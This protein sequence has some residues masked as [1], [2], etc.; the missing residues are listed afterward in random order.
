MQAVSRRL[1]KGLHPPLH[2]WLSAIATVLALAAL[3]L[4][5]VPAADHLGR[6]PSLGLAIVIGCAQLTWYR[7]GVLTSALILWP[8]TLTLLGALATYLIPEAWLPMAHLYTIVERLNAGSD[9]LDWRPALLELL[10]MLTLSLGLL[11]RTRSSLGVPL[12]QA[13]SALLL[14]LD[15]MTLSRWIPSSP[16]L[17]SHDIPLSLVLAL[18]VIAQFIGVVK[19]WQHTATSITRG[20]WPSLCLV[21]AT[22]WLWQIQ[23][24]QADRALVAKGTK[25]AAAMARGLSLELASHQEAMRRF[26]AIWGLY[27]Q[28]PSR[29]HWRQMARLYHRD[30]HYLLNLEFLT[31]DGQIVRVYPDAPAQASLVGTSIQELHPSLELNTLLNAAIASGEERHSSLLTLVQGMPG[32]LEYLPIIGPQDKVIGVVG[33]V[34]ALPPVLDALYLSP[35]H[36]ENPLQV[37]LLREGKALKTWPLDG[38]PGPWDI[39]SPID[40][41]GEPLTLTLRPSTELLLGLR[42][43]LGPITLCAGLVLAYLLYLV[44]FNRHQM[45]LQHRSIR[46]ANVELRREVRRSSRLQRRLTWLADHDDLTQL[47]NR[48][49]LHAY[50]ATLGQRL[51]IGLLLVDIDHFKLVNDQLGHAE[52]DRVLARI[53]AVGRAAVGSAG[54]F[55]RLGGE[56]FVALLADSS[57]ASALAMAEKIR[58]AI[59]HAGLAHAD[60]TPLTVSIGVAL[61]IAG[62]PRMDA[63]TQRADVAL[64]AAKRDGRNRVCVAPGRP[65]SDDDGGLAGGITV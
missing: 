3:L 65:A 5:T 64:Y 45:R 54:I 26:A 6:T 28:T 19:G 40:L 24:S 23:E 9:L 8:V 56:E 12:L 55:G 27:A 57:D 52:G 61:Q 32:F 13:L 38:H 59:R 31:P 39:D 42:S 35:E 33:M 30:F 63:L 58:L 25:E 44:L 60:G 29:R 2:Q 16:L 22:L 47:P 4:P 46:H 36:G 48:R 1:P 14:V 43:R 21:M 17:N 34:V 50:A 41:F 11:A 10:V 37:S 51:P 49:Q 18:L 15:Q 20:L 62:R 53:A 7:H